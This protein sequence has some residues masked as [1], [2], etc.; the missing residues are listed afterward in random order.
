MAP[1]FPRSRA[2]RLRTLGPLVAVLA[3]SLPGSAAASPAAAATLNSSTGLLSSALSAYAGPDGGFAHGIWNSPNTV[4]WSCNE[5]GPASAAAT[6]YVLTGARQPQLLS[7]AEQT[8]DTA[9][10]TRQAVD[11]SFSGPSGDTQSPDIATMFFGDEEGNAYLQLA[12]VLDPV[13]RARWRSSLMAAAMYLIRHGNLTWY[14]NGNINLGNTELFYLAWRASANPMFYAAYTQAWNFTLYPPQSQ[15]PGR[16]LHFAR[17]PTRADWSDGAGY[18]S[19]TGPGGTG[20]DA[21]YTSLQ[22]DEAAR[23]YLLS[24]D[25]RALRLANALVNMLLA[26]ITAGYWL[27]TSGGTR[28]TEANRQVPLLTSAFAVLGLDGGRSDLLARIAPQLAQEAGTVLAPWNAYGEVYRRG[29]G[30]DVSVVALAAGLPHPVG[31]AA[32]PA[33]AIALPARPGAVAHA[34]AGAACARA[35]R[36]TVGILASRIHP[37]GPRRPRR[38]GRHRGA[39]RRRRPSLTCARS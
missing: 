6:L 35:L 25:P 5:G 24:G 39:A 17:V 16:G 34:R 32:P 14:T 9:I 21:E 19:E 12:P 29:L 28:H 31:W 23:L 36:A 4:C 2:R 22:L 37:T 18:L 10:A 27:D 15:W 8:I 11:G 33:A 20:F 38:T 30:T 26:R 7:E 3:L 13:R 1:V